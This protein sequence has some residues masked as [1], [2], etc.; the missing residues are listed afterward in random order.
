MRVGRR[1]TIGAARQDRIRS[2]PD[3]ALT[4]HP[5]F[6]L[7]TSRLV[8]LGCLHLQMLR[9]RLELFTFALLLD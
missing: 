4:P 1:K 8:K 6:L 2:K 7:Q 9:L 3:G 5:R